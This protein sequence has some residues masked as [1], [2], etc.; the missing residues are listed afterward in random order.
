MITA[1]ET[2]GWAWRTGENMDA[3]CRDL[4]RKLF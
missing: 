2:A 3:F 1:P 4:S